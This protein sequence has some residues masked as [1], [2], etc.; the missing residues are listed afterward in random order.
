MLRAS[1]KNFLRVASVCDPGDYNAILKE[2]KEND[3]AVSYDFRLSLAK[4]TFAHTAEYDNAIASYLQDVDGRG[5]Y[6]VG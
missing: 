5:V 6:N 1:A 4:K 2:L 3:G